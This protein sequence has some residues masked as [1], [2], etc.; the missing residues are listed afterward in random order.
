MYKFSFV[1][2]FLFLIQSNLHSSDPRLDSLINVD[3]LESGIAF[4]TTVFQ[5]KTEIANTYLSQG[6]FEGAEE[7]FNEIEKH[8]DELVLRFQAIHQLNK[9]RFFGMQRNLEEAGKSAKNA[10]DLSKKADEERILA[11]ATFNLGTILMYQNKLDSAILHFLNARTYFE[12][13]DDQKAINSI[14]N[15]LSVLY[16]RNEDYDRA[17]EYNLQLV[18]RARKANDEANLANAYSNR[19][20]NLHELSREDSVLHYQELAYALYEKLGDKNGLARQGSNIG[21]IYRRQKEYAKAEKYL[22]KALAIY[23]EIKQVR[24]QSDIYLALGR[25]RQD[26]EKYEQSIDYIHNGLSVADSTH[27]VMLEALNRDLGISYEKNG[28]FELATKHLRIASSLQDS[29][30]IL[31]NKEA[32]YKQELKYKSK[33]LQDSLKELELSNQY[34][35]GKVKRKNG[36]MLITLLAILGLIISIYKRIRKQ[37]QLEV[38]VE[39]IEKEKQELIFSQK[40]LEAINAKLKA[41]LDKKA[42]VKPTVQLEEI[43]LVVRK[44][45]YILPLGDIEYI[46]SEDNGI[47]VFKSDSSSEWIDI[48]LKAIEA[49]YNQILLR[50]HRQYLLNVEKIKSISSGKITLGTEVEIPVGRVYKKDVRQRIEA[51]LSNNN[52]A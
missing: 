32:L 28:Q 17:L 30:E 14:L 33:A 15:N 12:K 4:D 1:I 13:F 38:T 48:K 35:I 24:P 18:T 25:L 34:I 9:I 21:V 11:Q 43:S 51:R 19:A 44:K 52:S 31:N 27:I 23:K 47:R 50:T 8:I 16:N 39:Q 41:E 42:E 22:L 29:L 49:D 7:K 6:N 26:Q 36:Y 10:I 45:T 20:I 37:N 3:K 46:K 5:R 40:E 2:F